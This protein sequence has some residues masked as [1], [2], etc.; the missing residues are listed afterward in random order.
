MK[1]PEMIECPAG[2]FVM[3]SPENEPGRYSD[4]TEHQVTLTQAFLMGKYPV[5][6]ELYEAV[7]G[8]N[9]SF[10]NGPTRPVEM[11]SWYDAVRF[12]N[13]LSAKLG[14]TPAYVIGV[15]IE[16]SVTCDFAS[17]GYRLP[18]EA[19]W[20]YAYRAGTM[21]TYYNGDSKAGLDDI[22]WYSANANNKTNPVGQKAPNAW[23]LHDM[24]GNVWDWTWDWYEGYPSAVSD[25]IGPDT[26]YHRVLRG[27]SWND[28]ANDARAAGRNFGYPGLRNNDSGFR[29]ARTK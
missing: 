29:L 11:V 14:L 2:T 21:T 3:G 13:A 12:C 24:A 15:G 18:I 22:A 7:M 28:N 27:G 5:T 19:E 17:P 8:K 1:Q 25:Y 10:F 26:G 23:G 20:E 4:E 6:Q 16:P 9:P